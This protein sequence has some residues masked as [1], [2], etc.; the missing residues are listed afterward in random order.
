MSKTIGVGIIGLDHWY[1]ALAAAYATKL[2]E[3]AELLYVSDPCEEKA[4]RISKVYSAKNWCTDYNNILHDSNVSAVI[5]TTTTA[6]HTKVAMASARAGKDIL[7]G[8]PIART[9]ADADEIIR[10][11]KKNNVLLMS[12][13]GSQMFSSAVQKAQHLLK[14]KV[15]GSPY[16][17]YLSWRAMP[18]LREPGVEDP[19]WFIDPAKVA[20]GAFMDHAIYSAALCQYFFDSDAVRVY[21]EMGKFLYKNYDLE[22]HGLALVRL[23]NGAMITLEA[24][25]TAPE[26][27]HL[28]TII[29]TDGQITISG[30]NLTVWSKK[31]PYTDPTTF[32]LRPRPL[33]YS[34]TYAQASI[35]TPPISADQRAMMNY[36]I[37]CV[38][39]RTD[40]VPTAENARAAL[41]VCLA[42]YESSRTGRPVSLPLETNT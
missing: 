19:G 3:N 13:S 39:K 25:W 26:T 21:A 33:A 32:D 16:A 10:T 24:T 6:E 29:G 23:R 8:K 7:V 18:A 4:E 35:P 9:L 1:W 15:I 28:Y 27:H 14:E 17:G 30:Q 2:N 38:V 31:P 34:R 40:P 22:D 12:M 42:A 20:G 5:I 11:A 41:E 36:F 37:D